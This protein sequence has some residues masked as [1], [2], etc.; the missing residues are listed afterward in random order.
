MNQP[1]TH[2]LESTAESVSAGTLDPTRPAARVRQTVTRGP[3]GWRIS[4]RE[5]ATGRTTL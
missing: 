3:D 5:I 2:V 1:T 4:R